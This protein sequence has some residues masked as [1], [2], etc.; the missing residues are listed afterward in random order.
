MLEVGTKHLSFGLSLTFTWTHLLIVSLMLQ[1][2]VNRTKRKR[3]RKKVEKGAALTGSERVKVIDMRTGK[4][5]RS[6]HV[7]CVP[8]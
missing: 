6:W 5:V 1:L 7:V 2:L 8:E 3:R 4:K